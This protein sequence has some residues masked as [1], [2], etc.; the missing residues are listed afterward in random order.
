MA[1]HTHCFSK[2]NL[3]VNKINVCHRDYLL[4]RISEL[5]MQ[6][7]RQRIPFFAKVNVRQP[8]QIEEEAEM[9]ARLWVPRQTMEHK[10]R[11]SKYR[12]VSID[13][14]WKTCVPNTGSLSRERLFSS[15][16]FLWLTSNEYRDHNDG[17]AKTFRTS[18][19]GE[20]RF[21]SID[22]IGHCQNSDKMTQAF[23]QN[24]QF[25]RTKSALKFV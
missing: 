20:S 2:I 7:I 23:Q 24:E 10:R 8:V 11:W 25:F 13:R 19:V 6:P 14:S 22:L 16:W 4:L 21:R 1:T 17:R 5:E 18:D 15:D 3:Q 9:I 12:T